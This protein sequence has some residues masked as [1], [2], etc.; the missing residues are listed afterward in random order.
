MKAANS[1]EEVHMRSAKGVHIRMKVDNHRLRRFE[2]A[3]LATEW[4]RGLPRSLKCSGGRVAHIQ[5][6]EQT[7]EEETWHR[8]MA[9]AIT[10]YY[11]YGSGYSWEAMAC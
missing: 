6:L 8:R 2:Q 10:R 9:L 5:S 4:A 7:S 1:G 11:G 3:P